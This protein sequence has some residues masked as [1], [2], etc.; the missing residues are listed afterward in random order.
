MQS[1]FVTCGQPRGLIWAFSLIA[2][3]TSLLRLRRGGW[4]AGMAGGGW[5]DED[6]AL[7]TRGPRCGRM[8]QANRT[9]PGGVQQQGCGGQA[10]R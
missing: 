2:T 7:L 3:V 6:T 10:V 8:Q 1:V 9:Q 5:W 4:V